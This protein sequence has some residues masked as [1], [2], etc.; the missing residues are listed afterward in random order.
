M[1]DNNE[2]GII[3]KTVW[4]LAFFLLKAFYSQ[5]T[6]SVMVPFPLVQSIL[7]VLLAFCKAIDSIEMVKKKYFGTLLDR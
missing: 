6:E 7:L 1:H 5:E 3:T 4:F 2:L